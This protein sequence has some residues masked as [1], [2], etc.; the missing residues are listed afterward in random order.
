MSTEKFKAT[1]S[2]EGSNGAIRGKIPTQMVKAMRAEPGDVLEFTVVGRTCTGARLLSA[3]EVRQYKADNQRG[4]ARTAAV[5]K[6]TSSKKTSKVAKSTV[7]KG[8]GKKVKK[9]AKTNKRRTEVEYD[10]APK[11]LKKLKL[12]GKFGK[13]K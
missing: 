1:I 7:A 3:K 4:G 2:Q 11:G 5:A 10:E 13:K 6:S 8:T 12:K 9:L